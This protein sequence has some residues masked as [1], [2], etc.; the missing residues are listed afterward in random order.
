DQSAPS[1]EP[2]PAPS[3]LP[4][5]PATILLVEDEASIRTLARTVLEEQGH[6]V[7]EA[8]TA[9]EDLSLSAQHQFP[10]HLLLTDVVMPGM[11]GYELAAR[12]SPLRPDMKILFTSGYTGRFT[13]QANAVPPGAFFLPKPFM[14]ETLEQKVRE[15]LG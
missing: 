2:P 8:S 5:R 7:L 15:A 14:P 3:S 1:T 6:I 10:V 11:D 9:A 4:H 12:L 13:T